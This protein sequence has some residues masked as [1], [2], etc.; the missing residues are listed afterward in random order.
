MAEEELA[1]E[2]VITESFSDCT[3]AVKAEIERL[4]QQAFLDPKFRS[5]KDLV[6]F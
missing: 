4:A 1:P 2:I 5:D 6:S 3:S